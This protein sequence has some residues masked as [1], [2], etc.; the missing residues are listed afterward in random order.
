MRKLFEVLNPDSV[1]HAASIID[2]RPYPVPSLDQINVEATRSLLELSKESSLCN[3]KLT[4]FVY[5]STIECGYSNN[6]C[7]NVDET[8]PYPSK[9]SNGYQR[10]KIEAEKL[11]LAANDGESGL[12]T[13]AL[14]P[15]HIFGQVR[16]CD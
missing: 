2:L 16:A 3:D 15:A 7:I 5:T 11:V 13:A 4:K 6:E 8:M 1:F 14:R 10:T 12:K 9:P